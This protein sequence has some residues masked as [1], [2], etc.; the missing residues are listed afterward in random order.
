LQHKADKSMAQIDVV[1]NS[2]NIRAVMEI[3]VDATPVPPLSKA[4]QLVEAI[5][6]NARRFNYAK[7]PDGW[8]VPVQFLADKTRGVADF[9]HF[10]ALQNG[11]CEIYGGLEVY[12][13]NQ[14][15]IEVASGATFG[16]ARDM[17]E[18]ILQGEPPSREGYVFLNP[19]RR[20]HLIWEQEMVRVQPVEIA[21]SRKFQPIFVSAIALQESIRQS[22]N[23]V[24]AF[25]REL[26]PILLQD[27]ELKLTRKDFNWMFGLGD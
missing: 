9:L 23:E 5:N 6:D 3:S 12:S 4:Q 20:L 14:R 1:E 11:G 17:V 16:T 25:A 18:A 24:V 10:E 7:T 22:W 19:Q 26:E 21:A 8:F 13:A 2:I 27:V 15:V